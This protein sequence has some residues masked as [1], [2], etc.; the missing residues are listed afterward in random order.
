MLYIV[1]VCVCQ[2]WLV[3]LVNKYGKLGG[4]QLLLDRFTVGPNLSVPVIAALIRPFG[5]CYEVLTPHVVL[6]FFMPIV[7]SQLT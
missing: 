4:F 6:Q 3:D 1:C 2:G 7:V 5:L